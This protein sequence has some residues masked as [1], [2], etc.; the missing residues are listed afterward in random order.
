M[1]ITLDALG[2]DLRSQEISRLIFFGNGGESSLALMEIGGLFQLV[3][4]FKYRGWGFHDDSWQL[5]RDLWELDE[6][7]TLLYGITG[8]H[9][10]CLPFRGFYWSLPLNLIVPEIVPSSKSG[11]AWL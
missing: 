5:C 6:L 3:D 7:D 9:R 11:K 1:G 4:L 10:I 8:I 2:R